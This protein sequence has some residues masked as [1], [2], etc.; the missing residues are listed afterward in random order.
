[1]VGRDLLVGLSVGAAV[2]LAYRAEWL[3][4]AWAGVAPLP[5]TGTGPLA[6]LFP[7]PPTPLYVLLRFLVVPIIIPVL[8]LSLSY[9][10][11]LVLRRERLAWIGVWLFFVLLF[12][13]PRLGPS[14]L[15]NALAIFWD[16]L[17]VALWVVALARFGLLAMAAA[18]F[19]EVVLSLVPLTADLSAWY[20]YQGVLG[21]LAVTGV[22]VYAFVTATRGQR[23]FRDGL[24]ADP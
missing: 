5:L 9:A 11:F 23:L 20:A 8:Y 22:A 13:F 14:A 16:G 4:R 19:G 1:M 17:R 3:S 7:G 15:G 24:F 6:L 10:F 12:I 2:M 18:L 21:A